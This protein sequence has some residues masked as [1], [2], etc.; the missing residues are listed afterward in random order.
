M[1]DETDIR[2]CA[3]KA[4]LQ[5]GTLAS[6]YTGLTYEDGVVAALRWVLGD[7]QEYPVEED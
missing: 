3:G 1:Q 4:E 6:S 5:G 2:E 7:T